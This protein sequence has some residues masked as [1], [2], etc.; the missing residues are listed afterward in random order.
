M[1]GLP[2]HDDEETAPAVMHVLVHVQDAHDVGAARGLPVVVHLLPGLGA[3]IQ[4]LGAGRHRKC[5]AH[6]SHPDSATALTLQR[7][8]RKLRETCDLPRSRASQRAEWGFES[9][10]P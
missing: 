5:Q 4:E 2:F 8:T 10:F 7:K 6:G 3:V 1:A 9:R